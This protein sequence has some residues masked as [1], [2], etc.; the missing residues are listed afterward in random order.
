LS[1][2]EKKLAKQT[3]ENHLL[4]LLRTMP[5]PP[6]EGEIRCPIEAQSACGS[7]GGGNGVQCTPPPRSGVANA[8]GTVLWQC[9]GYKLTDARPLLRGRTCPV[10]FFG[11]ETRIG[12]WAAHAPPPMPAYCFRM[13]PLPRRTTPWSSVVW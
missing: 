3:A 9:I 8:D 12:F 4:A 7:R 1:E 13:R 10:F 11:P 2:D 5:S 6:L